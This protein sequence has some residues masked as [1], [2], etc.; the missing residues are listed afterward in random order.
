MQKLFLSSLLIEKR[1][2]R[3]TKKAEADEHVYSGMQD[4]RCFQWTNFLLRVSFVIL[5]VIAEFL[6]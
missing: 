3:K 1:S 5:Y 2:Y 6:F 4:K